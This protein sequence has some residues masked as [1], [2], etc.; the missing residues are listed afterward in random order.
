[1]KKILNQSDYLDLP[2]LLE[3]EAQVQEICSQADDHKRSME[4]FLESRKKPSK[5][6]KR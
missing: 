5:K 3:L 1:M 2:S 4:T 6:G